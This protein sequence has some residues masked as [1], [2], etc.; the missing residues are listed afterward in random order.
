M[1][2]MPIRL[3]YR[4]RAAFLVLALV[5]LMPLS[6]CWVESIN[7]LNEGELFGA[8]DHNRIF[9]P[10]LVGTWVIPA[11]KCTETITITAENE[12]YTWREAGQ[13]EDCIE[14]NGNRELYYHSALYKLD[15]HLFLDVTARPEDVCNV[16]RAMHWIFLVQLDKNSFSMTPIDSDWLKKSVEAKTVSLGTLS[17]DTDTITATPN[18]LKAFCRKYADDNEAFKPTPDSVMKRK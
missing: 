13:G 18:E 1:P 3:Q 4:L 8:S 9:D 5:A 16:C 6:G 2:Y 17:N 7:G 14:N 15:N 10:A 12:E 11:D